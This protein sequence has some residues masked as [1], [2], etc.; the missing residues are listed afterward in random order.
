MKDEQQHHDN[1]Q[2]LFDTTQKNKD[3]LS[4]GAILKLIKNILLHIRG[5]TEKIDGI[6]LALSLSD[7]IKEKMSL[8][9][10]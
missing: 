7:C 6:L 9:M 2:S 10:Q 1:C 8:K 3:E 5:K 4:D